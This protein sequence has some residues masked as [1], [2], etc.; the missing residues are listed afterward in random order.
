MLGNEVSNGHTI[1]SRPKCQFRPPSCGD[2]VSRSRFAL[3]LLLTTLAGC[4]GSESTAPSNGGIDPALPNFTAK[5]D[6]AQWQATLATTVQNPAAGLYSITGFRFSGTN[7]Y[8][9]II[10]LYNIK[11]PGTYALGV[12]PSIPGGA[13]LLSLAPSGGWS[14][15]LNGVSGEFV[16]TTLTATRMVATFRFTATP[17]SGSTG[18]KEVTQGSLDLA[19]AGAGGVA[20]AN[21]GSVVNGTLAAMAFNASAASAIVSG[22]LPNQTLTLTGNNGT[23]SITIS[24][25][26]FTGVGTYQSST[27]LPIRQVGV[28]GIGGNLQGSWSTA[29]G[30]SA[31]VTVT[32]FTATR[33]VGSYSGSLSPGPNVSGTVAVNG[34][35][36]MGRP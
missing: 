27:A 16:I 32:G 7:Q 14:S 36:D 8:T 28:S 12:S 10:N 35:F 9:M 24:L 19:V 17:Q 26:A 21:Q 18:T 20:L 33:I 11:G 5:I 22:S 1:Q 6:G 25:A 31:T 4:G 13:G 34:T 2:R 23:Q 3:V 15:T 29:V 30:G